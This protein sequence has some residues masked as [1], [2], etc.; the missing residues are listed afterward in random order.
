MKRIIIPLVSI[1]LYS[2][3]AI[4]QTKEYY[5]NLAE[6]QSE[7][8]NY[9]EA[10]LNYS[11]A[12]AIDPNCY[13]CYESRGLCKYFIEDYDGVVKDFRHAITVEKTNYNNHLYCL[14]KIAGFP[15][16]RTEL[17]IQILDSLIIKNPI[18]PYYE[19]RAFFK[20][21][22][23][24]FKGALSDYNYVFENTKEPS[25][26]LYWSIAW[27]NSKL[28]NYFESIQSYNKVIE[29]R[30]KQYKENPKYVNLDKAYMNRGNCKIELKDY[31]GALMDFNNAIL[32]CDNAPYPSI[33]D[34]YN[35]KGKAQVLLK[36]YDKALIT[37]NKSIELNQNDVLSNKTGRL[38]VDNSTL[39]ESY[40][41]RGIAYFYLKDLENACKDWSKAGELGAKH[42]YKDIQKHCNN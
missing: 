14:E 34:L 22:I 23:G 24:D 38:D 9:K 21:E 12:I 13:I 32:V 29:I 17:A 11:K 27:C 18:I 37:L 26:S 30:K 41:Y 5:Y 42:A 20:T 3:L 19:K 8:N 4:S 25:G 1:I 15:M 33:S 31:R 28:G 7:N 6:K 35:C 36:E 16:N 2:T 10:I 39:A 40:Y